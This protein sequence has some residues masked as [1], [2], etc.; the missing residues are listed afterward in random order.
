MNVYK[1]PTAALSI[2]FALL[3]FGGV[4]SYVFLGG[5]PAGTGWTAPSFLFVAALLTLC[6]TP[7]GWRLQLA[8]AAVIGMAAELSGLRWGYPFGEYSYTDVL[9]PAVMGVPLAIGAA[10]LILFAYVRQMLAWFK[11]NTIIRAAIGAAWMTAIDLV[12]DPLAA[13]PLG[14]WTWADGG[15]YYGVPASN[16]FGWFIV[17]LLLFIIFR[18]SPERNRRATHVGLSIILFFTIIAVSRHMAGPVIAGAILLAAH[19]VVLMVWEKSG[20]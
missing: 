14:F 18:S 8:I 6:L 15:R 7:P 20:T 13:G 17:S 5:P 12:I 16:F 2:V 11:L 19:A 9:F 10:W 3:W 4:T 1:I